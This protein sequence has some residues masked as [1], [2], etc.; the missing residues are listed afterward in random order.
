MNETK[1][2]TYVFALFYLLTFAAFGGFMPFINLYL[3]VNQGF[4]GAQLGNFTFCTLIVSVLI[5]PIWGVLGDKTGK[6]KLLLMLS[7]GASIIVS[8]IYSLQTGYIAVMI[9]GIVLEICRS[10]IMPLT[11]VQAVNYTTK[12]K[13]NYGFIRS[14]GSLGFVFGSLLVGKVVSSFDYSPMLTIYITLLLLAFAISVLFPKPEKKAEVIDASENKPKQKGSLLLVLK[15]PHF[16]FLAVISLMT[17]ILMDSANSYVGIHM[18]NQ[19]HADP[20]SVSLFTVCTAL[21]EILLLGIIGKWFSKYGF[22]KIFLLNA[23]I[24]V[25]RYFIYIIA[26]NPYVF[27]AASLVH[28]IATGVSTVGNL[29]YLKAVIPDTSY[30]TAVTLY[31]AAI[32]VGR[33]I[34]SLVFGYMID[35]FGSTSIFIFALVIMIIAVG[36]IKKTHLF[37]EADKTIIAQNQSEE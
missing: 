22:K 30:G 16:L 27:L 25:I 19:L 17:V 28:C 7:L 14:M 26:P 9:S 31:N 5:V 12:H 2:Q 13:G 10:G 6:Y 33:A 35:W 1:K 23:I 24:L 8:F 20:N 3:Q 18:V 36:L 15:N 34:Y 37:A 32:A 21:P 11:D 4:T 29:S